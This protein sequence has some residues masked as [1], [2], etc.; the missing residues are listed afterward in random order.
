MSKIEYGKLINKNVYIFYG[1]KESDILKL[2]SRQIA[3]ENHI[4][5]IEIKAADHELDGAYLRRLRSYLN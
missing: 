2:R 4:K 5:A 3:K 1:S